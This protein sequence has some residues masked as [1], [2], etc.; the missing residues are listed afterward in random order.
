[1]Q[2]QVGRWQ[3]GLASHG[4]RLTGAV[5]SW[6]GDRRLRSAGHDAGFC[7]LDRG[8]KGMRRGDL[9][10]KGLAGAGQGGRNG[11]YALIR[12]GKEEK[13]RLIG[14]GLTQ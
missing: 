14:R 5:F 7:L 11:K 3:Y 8:R 4:K 12:A 13:G 6:T 10:I 9:G 1:M 2:L